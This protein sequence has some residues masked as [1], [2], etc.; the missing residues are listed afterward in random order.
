MFLSESI[1]EDVLYDQG[2][3][4][5]I[6]LISDSEYQTTYGYGNQFRAIIKFNDK[7]YSFYYIDHFNLGRMVDYVNNK[8]EVQCYEVFPCQVTRT[9]YKSKG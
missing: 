1:L 7:Y 3:E 6:S 5:N 9:E 2:E 4:H 8:K